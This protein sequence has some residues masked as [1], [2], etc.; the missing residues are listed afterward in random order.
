MMMVMIMLMM[1]II[2]I[3]VIA[4]NFGVDAVNSSRTVDSHAYIIEAII[5]RFVFLAK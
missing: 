3:I 2:M 1:I 5:S 4:Y